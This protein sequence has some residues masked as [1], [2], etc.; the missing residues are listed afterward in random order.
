MTECTDTEQNASAVPLSAAGRPLP[1]RW[2]AIIA[3]IWAGQAVSM[4]TSYAAG[5]AAVWYV[6]ETTGSALALSLM[7][8]C[9]M[10]PTG[11]LAPFGGVVADRFN[12]KTVMIAADLGVG[13]VSLGLGLLILTGEVSLPLIALFAA[14]RSV[15]QA[16]HSPA[17]MATLPLLVPDKHLVRINTLDQLLLSIVSIGAPAF[18]ILLYTTV[19]FHVVMFLDFFGALAAVAGLM[20]AKI[21]TV[22]ANLHDGWRALAAR[23]GLLMLMVAVTL[24]TMIFSPLSAVYPLMTYSYFGGDGYMASI[25][26]AAWG[27]G[28]IV[29]SGV[30]MVWGGGRRLALLMVVACVLTGVITVV[31]GLLPP[32][33]FAAF[34]VLCGLMAVPCAWFNAPTMT[35]AQRNVPEEKLGRV[36]GLMSAGFGLASPVGVALGGALAEGIGVAPFFVVDGVLCIVLGAA[37]YL[38]RSIR[39]LDAPASEGAGASVSADTEAGSGASASA[40]PTSPAA[41]YDAPSSAE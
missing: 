40:A 21:P 5:Y 22:L 11:L 10:L 27:I 33:A 2:L 38:P 25:T 31:C 1:R 39:A 32:T 41:R 4:V 20:L 18:G 16:F 7:T 23:R 37:M 9:A 28:M 13:I 6:T 3:T 24:G 34:A 12:R 19:G 15:G 29:G 8:I 30:I 17:M 35:L 26:E 14:A 36:M